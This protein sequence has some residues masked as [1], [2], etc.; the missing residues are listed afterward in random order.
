MEI[1]INVPD[2]LAARARKQG[3]SLEVYVQ[4]ILAKETLETQER[5]QL[6]REATERIFELRKQNKLEG[7]RIR[8]LIRE[9]HK[10]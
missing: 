5:L 7:T 10:Y 3:V 2:K 9:G 6:I 1:T 8:D 4:Q